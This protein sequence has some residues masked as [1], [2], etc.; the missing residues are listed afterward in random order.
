MRKSVTRLAAVGLVVP[1]VVAWGGAA[2]AAPTI[3]T[4][5]G[6]SAVASASSAV[7]AAAPYSPRTGV[8]F[9]DPRNRSSHTINKHIR[10]S[11]NS[12]PR[13]SS[14]RIV[15]WNFNSDAY[16]RALRDA[17]NRGV[18]VR[19]IMARG[20]AL[21]QGPG[22]SYQ[23]TKRALARRNAQRP[24]E[25]RSW[26]RVCR[27]SCRGTTGIVHS[28]FYLFSQAGT[29][30][31]VVIS[32]SANLTQAAASA[33]WN[34][35]FTYVNRRKIWDNYGKIFQQASKD[36]PRRPA[37]YEFADAEV[38]GWFQPRAGQR[39]LALR[40]LAPVKCA[41]ATGGSGTNGRTKIR[42]GQAVF[43]GEVGAKIAR[44]VK[45]L[46]RAGCDIKMIYTALARS[47]SAAL[48]GIPKR[49][50]A[51]DFDGDG[52]YDRYLHMKAIA[53]SGHYGD[54]TAAYITMQGSANWSGM[55]VQSDEQGFIIRDEAVTRTYANRIDQLFAN[56]PRSVAA[57]L[58]P[59]QMKDP[60]SEVEI[61][62]I[63]REF[64][65]KSDL[66]QESSFARADRLA[67]SG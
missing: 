15:T 52:S 22:G 19:V 32:T 5:A 48:A 64:R 12:S 62:E 27:N 34:D 10:D 26:I 30:R 28:K 8:K 3:T 42:I 41:G 50:M 36:R 46:H 56:P 59:S 37:Y 31:N 2:P 18:T 14:I 47:S 65:T 55:A 63:M 24:P 1:L 44:R 4:T 16:T 25:R 43:N 58:A 45:A 51:Q 9:N 13:G 33:Q 21:D 49:H 11:I 6:P 54:N 17:H 40:L 35:A 53:I 38:R 66:T 39:H 57:R 67:A 20:L 7:A 29:S 61:P 23:T 60:Y